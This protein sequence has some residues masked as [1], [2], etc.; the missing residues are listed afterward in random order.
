MRFFLSYDRK[1]TYQNKEFKYI[2]TYYKT[3]KKEL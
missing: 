1:M 3:Y 2:T